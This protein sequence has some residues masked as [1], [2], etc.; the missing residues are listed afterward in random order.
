M[1]L[2]DSV[3]NLPQISDK[4][5]KLL[6][7]L[8]VLTVRDLLTHFPRYHKDTTEISTIEQITQPG[9]Y[10]IQATPSQ[11]KSVRLR[12][13][14]RTLQSAILEDSTGKIKATW[15]NQPYIAKA[16][17]V[18]TEYLFL[19]NAKLNKDKIEF[20][21][22]NFEPIIA[23]R[24]LVHLGRLTPQ[25]PL[26]NG[27]SIKWL[28]NRIK[29]LVDNISAVTDLK[30]ESSEIEWNKIKVNEDILAGA[31]V[32]LPQALKQFHFPSD[33]LSQNLAKIKLSL[34]ELTQLQI[35]MQK[36]RD[37]LAKVK[38]PSFHIDYS[39]VN[40]LLES[41][42][43]RLTEDQQTSVS[44]VLSD[45]SESK[46]MRRLVQGDV[47]SGKTVVAVIAAY[48]AHLAGFQTVVLT[49]TTILAKQHYLT[50]SKLLANTDASVSLV[51]S[52][53]K[54]SAKAEDI[55]GVGNKGNEILIGTTAVLARK[56]DL[57]LNLGLVIT[58]EQHR[59]GVSQREELSEIL[60][61][62]HV[63]DRKKSQGNVP[64]QLDMTA[65][66]IPRTLALALFGDLEI[67]DILTKPAGR[68]PINTHIVPIQKRDDAYAWVN[69]QMALGNQV[70][71]MCPLVEE[72]DNLEAKSAKLMYA[73]LSEAFPNHKI[74]LLHGQLK[75]TEKE[76]VMQAFKD[77]QLDMLV[78][79]SV[80]E[81]GIDVP[82]ACVMMIEDADRFGLAQLHQIRGRV[83]RGEKQSWCFLFSSNDIS[84]QAQA[85]L[86][87]FAHNNNGLE[88]AEFDLKSRGPGE[89]YGTRQSGIPNLKIADL[90]DVELIK[91]SRT[92]AEQL[93]A[94]GVERISLFA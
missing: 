7:K 68:L 2:S 64:H 71:W 66:P 39:Q 61:G 54:A 89:V 22:E 25:Y 17:K 45:L 16:F 72:S 90:S 83:G 53:N 79:T 38:S 60:Q 78:C 4:Y 15:F 36:R 33:E 58:D 77:H 93:I 3:E 57:V 35:L 56:A 26:T 65:T 44:Q 43:F 1:L 18:D 81:V 91:A 88:I 27:I 51:T 50:F 28:R 47:G 11:A 20:Y 55:A 37:S 31:K 76:S 92:L 23:E 29:Y 13:G 9:K 62:K 94:K 80:I 24:E 48:A 86:D 21:P 8:N 34:L 85:R 87:F 59:F 84:Q 14:F 82:N 6:A 69:E 73:E 42:P 10:V 63:K 41:L 67:S 40:K 5:A 19:G 52:E 32:K 30:D 70:Y 46:P 74:G 12:G 49:P 75:P